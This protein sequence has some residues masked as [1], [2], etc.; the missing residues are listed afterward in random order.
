MLE[1]ARW[2]LLDIVGGVEVCCSRGLLLMKCQRIFLFSVIFVCVASVLHPG[3]LEWSCS[4][5]A[6]TLL[7]RGL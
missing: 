3:S 7:V 1:C 5:G 6:V 2:S 4:S